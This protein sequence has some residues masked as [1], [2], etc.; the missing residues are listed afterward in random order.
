VPAEHLALAADLQDK[1]PQSMLNFQRA[2]IHWRRTLPQ[3]T[4]GDIA[5]Y[6]VPEQALALRRD[7]PG[8]PSVLAV[9][10]LTNTPVSF[11]WPAAAGAGKLE[12]HGLPGEVSGST[13][14]LPPYGGWFGTLAQQG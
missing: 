13:V 14:T 2:I 3:L 6:D 9:F 7:L 8:F 12:G 4:R 10:N 11:D 1:D 5:F